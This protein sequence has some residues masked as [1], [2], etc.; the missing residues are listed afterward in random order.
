M[1]RVE[2]GAFIT[3]IAANGAGYV[4]IVKPSMKTDA[5]LM[6]ETE[7]RFDYVEGPEAPRAGV[8]TRERGLNLLNSVLPA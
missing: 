4:R 8:G 7:K 6:S 3:F 5:S 1:V 2:A